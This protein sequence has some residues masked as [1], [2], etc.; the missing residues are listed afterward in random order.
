MAL[1]LADILAG[2]SFLLAQAPVRQL[3]VFRMAVHVEIHVAIIRHVGVALL[4]QRLDHLDLLWNVAAGA[5]ADVGAH[6][7][8][9]VHVFEVAARVGLDDL[10]GLGL[11]LPRLLENA[12]LA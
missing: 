11:R 6:H 4:Q 8:E 10:H 12:I 2:A 3:A 5:R 9:R 7:T 1:V